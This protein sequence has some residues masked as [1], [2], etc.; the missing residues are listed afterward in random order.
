MIPYDFDNID[1]IPK[2]EQNR[3]YPAARCRECW[4]VTWT[5][6]I[7]HGVRPAKVTH[8]QGCSAPLGRIDVKKRVHH[9]KLRRLYGDRLDRTMTNG[10][11]RQIV[12]ALGLDG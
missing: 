6:S 11:I 5:V 12:T 3:L 7:T 9:R 2:E 10:E 4:E 8:R 1:E